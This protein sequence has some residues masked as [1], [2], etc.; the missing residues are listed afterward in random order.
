[1]EKE[2]ILETLIK[3]K[4]ILVE[5]GYNV[6]YIGLYGSQNYNLDDSNSDI[7]ARAIVLPTLNDLIFR[8]SVSTV[9]EVDGVGAVDVKDLITYYSVIKKGN[10]AFIEPIRSEYWIGDGTIRDLLGVIPANP[11]AVFG[12]MLEKQKALTHKYPSKEKE[13]ELFGCDPKQLH[14]IIRLYDVLM[15]NKKNAKK[16]IETAY[17]SYS[18]VLREFM[19]GVKRN[20]LETGPIAKDAAEEM[21]RQYIALAR[22]LLD[23]YFIEPYKIDEDLDDK[24]GN[25]IEQQLEIMMKG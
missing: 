9:I 24:V 25:Y 5:K 21:A 23:N 20:N 19:L 11:K 7:D 10:T 4:N 13:F 18:G 12:T 8:R 3:Y 6:I 22:G 15:E 2:V 16:Y 17:L 14:H 1:M